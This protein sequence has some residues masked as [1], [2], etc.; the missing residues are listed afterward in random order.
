MGASSG[1]GVRAGDEESL[2]SHSVGPTPPVSVSRK[3]R[4]SSL[5]LVWCLALS[6]G[7]EASYSGRSG[8]FR[9]WQRGGGA[10]PCLT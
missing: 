2:F 8:V 3:E 4:F 5:M 7:D 9:R 10:R 6:A 1:R